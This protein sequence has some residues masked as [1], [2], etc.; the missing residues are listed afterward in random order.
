MGGSDASHHYSVM[1]LVV[2]SSEDPHIARVVSLIKNKNINYIV[3]SDE[4]N[5][6]VSLSISDNNFC[7]YIRNNNKKYDISEFTTVWW[8][9]KPLIRFSID[10]K[11]QDSVIDFRNEEWYALSKGLIEYIPSQQW[12]NDRKSSYRA[13]IK[14]IQLIVAKILDSTYPRLR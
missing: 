14:I 3:L 4:N 13:N 10:D 5:I 8:R 9:L 6:N 2:G 7:Y 1:I 12:M 11:F